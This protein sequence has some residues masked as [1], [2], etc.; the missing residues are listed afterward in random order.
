MVCVSCG[1]K[2]TVKEYLSWKRGSTQ[3]NRGKLPSGHIVI[4]CP[5]C[6]TEMAWDSITGRIVAATPSES[7]PQGNRPGRFHRRVEEPDGFNGK[8]VTSRRISQILYWIGVG[9]AA[10]LNWKTVAALHPIDWILLFVI[11]GSFSYGMHVGAFR[12]ALS[13]SVWVLAMLGAAQL[14]P[15]LSEWMAAILSVENVSVFL[16][17]III[18]VVA[19]LILAPLSKSL[20]NALLRRG[21]H[22]G[23]FLGG[24]LALVFACFLVLL[25]V[26]VLRLTPLSES[27]LY[28]DSKVI[29]LFDPLVT[30]VVSKTIRS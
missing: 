17:Q 7:S 18:F 29:Q 3:G 30:S 9:L 16:G 12:Q 22:G 5:L 20:T 24:V 4:A 11:F 10:T 23:L 25:V 21:F 26:L 2:A 8:A 1:H 15:W 6:D 27:S 19:L 28:W 13:L 14:G